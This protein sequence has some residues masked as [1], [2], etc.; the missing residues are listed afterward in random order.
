MDERRAVIGE[1]RLGP[2]P[3]EQHLEGLVEFVQQSAS[4]TSR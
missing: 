2:L 4:L 3:N 1:F